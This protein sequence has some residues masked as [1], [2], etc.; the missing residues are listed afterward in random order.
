MQAITVLAAGQGVV[1]AELLRGAA[2]DVVGLLALIGLYSRRHTGRELLMVYTCFNVGLFAAL[3]EIT[4][5]KF[6]AGVGFGLFGVLSII[7]LR[8]RSFSNAEIG[9]F[10]LAL[11]LAL[12]N[13]LPGRG[14]LLSTALSAAVLVAVG[15]ADHPSL[16]PTLH[17]ARVTLDRVY[18][19]SGRLRDAVRSV[20]AGE[21]VEVSVLEID[22]VRDITR[23]AVR[24]RR[25]DGSAV[26]ELAAVEAEESQR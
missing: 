20:L 1:A 12:V 7:R 9:Y 8:S 4:S 16:H 18:P 21:I 23:V 24:Y 2:V 25:D 11:V 13:G 10:F 14:L 17:T 19:D 26:S 15:F 5:G 22:T 3:S 6:P